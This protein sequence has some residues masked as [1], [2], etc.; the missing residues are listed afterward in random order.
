MTTSALFT[1]KQ[2]ATYL[3]KIMKQ[4]KKNDLFLVRTSIIILLLF[5]RD[6]LLSLCKK[7]FTFCVGTKYSK[8]VFFLWYMGWWAMKKEN[9]VVKRGKKKKKKPRRKE[10]SKFE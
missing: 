7:K 2:L 5:V 8:H 10:I 9:T 1:F 6:F 4:K 3:P